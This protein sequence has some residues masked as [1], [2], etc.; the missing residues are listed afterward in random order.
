[1]SQREPVPEL[2]EEGHSNDRVEVLESV[3]SDQRDRHVSTSGVNDTLSERSTKLCHR[4]LVL[5]TD[6]RGKLCSDGGDCWVLGGGLL[7]EDHRERDEGSLAD[8]VD[9]VLAEGLEQLD[10]LLYVGEECSAVEQSARGP[11]THRGVSLGVEGGRTNRE[12]GTGASDTESDGRSLPDVRVVALA[13]QLNDPR[14]LGR[15]PAED[16]TQRG[17]GRPSNVVRHVRHGHVE[18]LS[19]RGIVGRAGV[20]EGDRVHSSVSKDGIL[21][22]QQSKESASGRR[23]SDRERGREQTFSFIKRSIHPSASSSLPYHKNAIPKLKPR[24]IF[25]CCVS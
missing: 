17:H 18:Q 14:H 11:G 22:S 12:T 2:A 10:S 21:Q 9:R 20:G 25:S 7:D 8:K 23:D 24:M 6:D 13:K 4:V 15:V 1:M 5:V 19:N 3:S 16:E